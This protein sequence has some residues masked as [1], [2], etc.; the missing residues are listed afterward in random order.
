MI[1]ATRPVQFSIW[2][3]FLIFFKNLLAVTQQMRKWARLLCL[4]SVSLVHVR[5]RVRYYHLIL[6]N[7]PN[8]FIL[9]ERKLARQGSDC[10]DLACWNLSSYLMSLFH[11]SK[12]LLHHTSFQNTLYCSMN[13]AFQ[14]HFNSL[15]AAAKPEPV[16]LIQH[17]AFHIWKSVSLRV[18]K[19][20]DQ[21]LYKFRVS[22]LSKAQIVMHPVRRY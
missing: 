4:W 5:F 22:H 19:A 9:S 2:A 10:P 21:W 20:C 6:F 3:A 7:L 17:P 15:D 12:L 14:P 18:L 11:I 13:S 8:N 16:H 1:N